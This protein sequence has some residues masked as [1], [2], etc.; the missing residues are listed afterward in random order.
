[1]SSVHRTRASILEEFLSDPRTTNLSDCDRKRNSVHVAVIVMRGKV[2]AAATNRNGSRSSGSGYS[3]H[4]IHAEKNVIKQ[5]GDISKLRGADMYVMRISRDC[6]K[7]HTDKFLCSKPCDQC[8]IF[9]EKC[10]KEYGLKNVYF[11][12]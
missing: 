1:M 9:L 6:K 4:S 10:M 12:A 7:V 2:L 11:T 3:N 8:Q 5:L